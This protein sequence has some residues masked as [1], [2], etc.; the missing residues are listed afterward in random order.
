MQSSTPP[1]YNKESFHC[2]FCAVYAH[3]YWFQGCRVRRGV[4]GKHQEVADVSF[5]QC[6][7]C[8]R[9]SVWR[10]AMMIYPD[11]GNAPLPHPDLPG[12]VVKDYEEARSILTKSPRGATALLRLLIQKL[13]Q[14][15]GEPGKDLNADI[16]SLVKKGLPEKVRQ[17]LDALRVIGNNAVHPGQIDLTDDA[18]TATALFGLVNFIAEKMITEPKEIERLHSLIPPGAIE[19]I[20]R[21]DKPALTSGGE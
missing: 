14:Q 13:C 5:C 8:G 19:Q 7:H 11:G 3:Q 20:K 10:K 18:D 1:A 6:T 16:G 12:E 9:T 4:G 17:A 15:L 21:R 2:P